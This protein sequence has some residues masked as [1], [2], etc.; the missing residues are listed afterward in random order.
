[1]A[2]IIS[3]ARYNELQGRIAALL[4]VGSGDKGY[5]QV[6]SSSSQPIATTV[7][8][9]HMN[10]LYSDFEKVYVHILGTTPTNSGPI[11]TTI[12]TVAIEDDITEAL[13]A[14]YET[15]INSLESQRFDISLTQATT[16]SAGVNS[17]KNG[18]ATP[19][20]GTSMPQQIN[21]TI[22]VSFA[23][24]NARRGFFNAGGQIR[25][26]AVL[27]ISA[28]PSD[29]NL[30][31]N[32]D[33]Q[34]MLS[35]PGQIQFKRNTTTKTSTGGTVYAIGNENLTSTYQKIFL[36]EGGATYSE[37]KWY[38]EVKEKNTSTITFN[39][40][41]WDQ[42][43][44]S[45][46]ADEYIAGVLTSSFSHLRASGSYVNTPAPSYTKTSDL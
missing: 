18:A 38:I 37:N 39:V 44:G 40:V 9:T 43:V 5:N 29:T 26:D 11:P 21:H 35:S 10:D 14:A 30:A 2:E 1:M 20:G 27:D 19:W 46:G 15:L 31:K 22:D 7:L 8:A 36:K 34:T 23:S 17:V 45:G 32:Q 3:A 24:P 28:I 6:V 25:L 12:A 33:W 4:G 42:D 41:Y 16:S 13:Y